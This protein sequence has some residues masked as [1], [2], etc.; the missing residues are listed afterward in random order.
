MVSY[1]EVVRIDITGECNL[2]C[3]HCQASMFLGQAERDLTT[4]EWK[5]FLRQF[6][7]EGGL[8]VTFLGGEPFLRRDLVELIEFGRALGLRSA[9]TTHGLLLTS[10]L[11]RRCFELG[12]VLS[13]SIDGPDAESHDYFRGRGTFAKICRILRKIED[14]RGSGIAGTL[15][16][17]ATINSKSHRKVTDLFNFAKSASADFLTIAQI[18][19]GGRAAVN[20]QQISISEADLRRAATDVL[21][22]MLAL[23]QQSHPLLVRPDFITHRLKD[24]VEREIGTQVTFPAKLDF[25]GI[26]EFYVQHDGNVFPSQQVSNMLPDVRQGAERI[27]ITFSGN[28][29]RQATLREIFASRP[30]ERFRE[31]M[32]SRAYIDE[33]HACKTCVHKYVDCIPGIGRY[34]E[35]ID[36]PHV[37]CQ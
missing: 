22:E 13:L 9:V 21:S 3:L 16:L 12:C 23:Q 26:T 36:S 2:R 33:Y 30:F 6:A 7:D 24:E 32:M 10:E 17:S 11:I 18:H 1:P 25:S 27:G 14:V 15:G 19:G 28:N 37:F 35:G 34:F 5:S 4:S 29:I 31:L 8:Y 20:W